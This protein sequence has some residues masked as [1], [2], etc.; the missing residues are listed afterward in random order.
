MSV[1]PDPG[2]GGARC[3]IRRHL[4]A[5]VVALTLVIAGTP[6]PAAPQELDDAYWSIPATSTPDLE[7]GL[8]AAREHWRAN[9]PCGEVTFRL[10]PERLAIAGGVSWDHDGLCLIDIEGAERHFE[11]NCEL[12]V[13]EYGHLLG[14]GHGW[15]GP[16][17]NPDPLYDPALEGTVM[18]YRVLDRRG[19]VPACDREHARRERLTERWWKISD[20]A[21]R[22]RVL[23]RALRRRNAAAPPR[24]CRRAAETAA[25]SRRLRRQITW[26][27][28]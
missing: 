23:C 6:S 28:W 17:G 14:L 13:H 19:G 25:R 10:I 4:V 20:S 9:P 21:E 24:R 22:R 5:I 7:A 27:L 26:S 12:V 15:Q 2:P 11:D 8:A 1:G 18:D 3:R 16:P